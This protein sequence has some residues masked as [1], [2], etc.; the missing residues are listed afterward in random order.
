VPGEVAIFEPD[1]VHATS[2]TFAT[3]AVIDGARTLSAL[4]EVEAAERERVA[5]AAVAEV[6]RWELTPA[7]A[8]TLSD[9]FGR[10]LPTPW[11]AVERVRAAHGIV[12]QDT[13]GRLAVALKQDPSPEVRDAL[14][15]IAFGSAAIE[16]ALWAGEDP[17]DY[18]LPVAGR[19]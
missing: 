10:E 6:E 8:A 3:P 18:P 14:L 11:E 16:T 1:Y 7:R 4:R 5:A 17:P 15:V 9:A 13:D 2:V 12:D 19:S